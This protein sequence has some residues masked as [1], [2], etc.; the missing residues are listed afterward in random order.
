M[1][2]EPQP[3][4]HGT[5]IHHPGEVQRLQVGLAR[6]A[7]RNNDLNARLGATA[8]EALILGL[9]RDSARHTAVRL[10]QEAAELRCLLQQHLAGRPGPL[11]ALG[12]YAAHGYLPTT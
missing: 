6:L 8:R 9:E 10:E 1:R 4:D 7:D 12:H 2:E 3:P 11:A 5:P